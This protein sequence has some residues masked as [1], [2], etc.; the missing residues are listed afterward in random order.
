MEDAVPAWT[1][2]RLGDPDG[3]SLVVFIHGGFWRARFNTEAIGPLARA[4]ASQLPT[5]VWNLEY[6]RVGMP[7]GGWPGTAL[8]VRDAAGAAMQA[9]AGRPV[10]FVGHSAGG[11][12]A[13]WAAR[14][15]RPQLV[16]S[17]AGVTDLETAARAGIGENAVTAFLGVTPD[18]GP[19][20]YADASPIRRLPLGTPVVLIH[21][22][23]DDRVPVAQSR[24]YAAAAADAGDDCELHELAGGDHFELV[25]PGGRAWSI[26]AERLRLPR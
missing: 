8:A 6:P 20:V 1:A 5:C 21:A 12:L 10:A 26:V 9:A 22:D 18:G 7:G 15:H 3:A 13:L 19:E 25:D 11:Q 23:A 16:I 14:E 24:S 2:E 17:L 4:C